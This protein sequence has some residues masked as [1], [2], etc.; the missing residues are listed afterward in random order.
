MT[1]LLLA[2]RSICPCP[3]CG[4]DREVI[5]SYG[6]EL[7]PC[8]YC[9]GGRSFAVGIDYGFD[10]ARAILRDVNRNLIELWE[11]YVKPKTLSDRQLIESRRRYLKEL[12]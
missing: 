6:E 9:V 11:P 5:G 10:Q 8:Y 12:P 3:V 7:L 4:G 1:Q 2:E